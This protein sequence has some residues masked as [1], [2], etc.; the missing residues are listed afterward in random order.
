MPSSSRLLK[1]ARGGLRLCVI[2]LLPLSL[3]PAG[4]CDIIRLVRDTSMG[5]KDSNT[6]LR[7]ATA[8]MKQ[9]DRKSVV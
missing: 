4:G 6:G 8:V 5:I 7:E 1:S 3:L 2:F 9:R